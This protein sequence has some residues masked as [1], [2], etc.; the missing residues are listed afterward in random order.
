[1]GCHH[2]YSFAHPSV[3][4][5]G[6]V[7]LSGAA[8]VRSGSL[9]SSPHPLKKETENLRG[10]M[11]SAINTAAAAVGSSR[12]RQRPFLRMRKQKLLV[13]RCGGVHRLSTVSRD[14]AL[15]QQQRPPQNFD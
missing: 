7:H 5:A 3:R 12:R 1:M 13:S 9:C 14:A 4:A 8:T 2:G 6:A 15:L 10:E 11:R